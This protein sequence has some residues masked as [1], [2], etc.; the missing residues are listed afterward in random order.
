MCSLACNYVYRISYVMIHRFTKSL[1]SRELINDSHSEFHQNFP[2]H[3]GG[4]PQAVST[5]TITIHHFASQIMK[6]LA[7]E[8]IN[9]G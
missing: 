1:M 9:Y 5:T 4:E 3:S 6:W 8:V 2:T 7:R